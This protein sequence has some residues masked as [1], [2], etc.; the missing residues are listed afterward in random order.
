MIITRESIQDLH[1]TYTHDQRHRLM[2]PAPKWKD[3]F[4]Q[5]YVLIN[6][7][8]VIFRTMGGCFRKAVCNRT[9]FTSE[10]ISP[11]AGLEPGTARSV[12]Q[13]LNTEVSGLQ[14]GM[15]LKVSLVKNQQVPSK[16]IT[17]SRKNTNVTQNSNGG[18]RG[19]AMVLGNLKFRGVRLRARATVL[20]VGAGGFVWIFVLS[21]IIPCLWKTA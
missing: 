4:L 2:K 8:S 21:P 6:S 20:T 9:P 7:I 14:Q 19:R 17:N 13:R 16:Y 5:F 12:D 10:K 15:I 18:C 11:R 1:A 3:G